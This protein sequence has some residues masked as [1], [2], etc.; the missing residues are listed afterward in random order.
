[1]RGFGVHTS[2]WA[3][4][5]TREA[6]RSPDSE[7][8][9]AEPNYL[10]Y[11]STVD[12]YFYPYQWNLFDR[13]VMSG[14]KLSN[15]GIHAA[16]AWNVSQGVGVTVALLD[17][18]CAYADYQE[19]R[20]APDLATP[21]IPASCVAVGQPRMDPHHSVQLVRCGNQLQVL[22]RQDQGPTYVTT[23]SPWIQAGTL[24]ALAY[25][26]FPFEP[27]L[28]VY[29]LRPTGESPVLVGLDKC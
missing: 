21:T 10:A 3:M 1:M 23:L 17:T 13:G 8:A 25:A 29:V 11:A 28:K 14:R 19:Y 20:Q 2:M 26:T 18:G 7:V 24:A 22:G 15:Y 9:V 27:C 16:S 5:W 4:G 12:P 6:R